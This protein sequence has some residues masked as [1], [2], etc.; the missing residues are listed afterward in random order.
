VSFENGKQLGHEDDRDLFPE[1][2]RLI[3]Q[4]RSTVVVLESVRVAARTERMPDVSMKM[5]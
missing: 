5:L 4:A 2:L 3:A 1:A